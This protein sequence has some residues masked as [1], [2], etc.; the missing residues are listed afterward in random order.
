LISRETETNPDSQSGPAV[1]WGPATKK[2]E[3]S[4]Q[5]ES[6][7]RRVKSDIDVRA[8][9]KRKWN[10]RTVAIA[11]N[12]EY[13]EDHER[14]QKKAE[15]LGADN[16]SPLLQAVLYKQAMPSFLFKWGLSYAIDPAD[17]FGDDGANERPAIK[18]V[19]PPENGDDDDA[20]A[21]STL[22]GQ[23]QIGND[24]KKDLESLWARYTPQYEKAHLNVATMQV[25][26]N[27]T[28]EELETAFRKKI[29]EW[30]RLKKAHDEGLG[31][32]KSPT[33]RKRPLEDKQSLVAFYLHEYK[34]YDR[35]KIVKELWP[36]EARKYERDLVKRHKE[37][38]EERELSDAERKAFEAEQEALM[39]QGVPWDKATSRLE[40]KYDLVPLDPKRSKLLKRYYDR[41]RRA[42][43]II[44]E[45]TPVQ[46]AR[47]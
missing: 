23:V 1:L 27:R 46:V 14:R 26:M 29:R 6:M 5:E 47:E 25:D 2:Q 35:E 7:V 28:Y 31:W 19:E 30:A 10:L 37:A 43:E 21:E 34:G 44:N 16:W 36:N 20:R 41:L 18:F 40:K 22:I 42:K 38:N 8:L 45:Y 4:L 24:S 12:L 33:S 9:I 3:V 39:A 11:L 17:P 15:A 13:R 32:S